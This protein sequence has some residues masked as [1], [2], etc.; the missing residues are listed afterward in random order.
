VAP[1]PRRR[2]PLGGDAGAVPSLPR[3]LLQDEA[4]RR[5]VRLHTDICSPIAT[6]PTWNDLN[7][8]RA[9]VGDG[10]E[11]WRDLIEALA[12]DVVLVSVA[13]RH[14]L[15]LAPER[16]DTWESL[17]VIERSNPYHVR[18]REL[19]IGRHSVLAVFGRAAQKPFGTVLNR[20]K[21]AIGA[22]IRSAVD[23]R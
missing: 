11:L 19:S 20:D 8:A 10:F 13:W 3:C 7:G 15:R 12:P 4:V 2:R 9:L 5:L 18:M 17:Y 22:A 21:P 16:G 6:T 23:G 14:L 1:V